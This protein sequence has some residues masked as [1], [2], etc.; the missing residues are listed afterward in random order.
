MDATQPEITF[1][2]YPDDGSHGTFGEMKVKWIDLGSHGKAAQLMVFEDSWDV[3][4]SFA[5]LI[6][7]LN[8]LND[9]NP[10]EEDFV[11]LLIRHGFRDLTKYP[12]TNN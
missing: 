11:N 9:T 10:T 4:A 1:G 5:D 6:H 7:G 8:E 2:L 12:E 3:L